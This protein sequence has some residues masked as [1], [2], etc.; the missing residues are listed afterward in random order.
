MDTGYPEDTKGMVINMKKEAVALTIAAALALGGCAAGTAGKTETPAGEPSAPEEVQKPPVGESGSPV[1]EAPAPAPEDAGNVPDTPASEPEP[2]VEEGRRDGERFEA[3]IILEGMEETV[4]YEHLRNE[5]VGVE[6]DYDYESFIRQSTPNRERFISEWDDPDDPENYLEVRYSP[7][8]AEAAAA[9]VSAEL[10][11]EYEL[12]TETR[13]LERAGDC[14][15]IDASEV[16]GGGYMPDLLQSVYIIPWTDGC[17]IVT[18]HYA[19]EGAE[20]FGRRFAYMAHTLSVID[21]EAPGALTDEQALA[22]VRKY[23][24]TVNPELENAVN[25]EDRTIYWDISSSDEQEVVVVF[26][27]YTGSLTRYYVDRAT[28]DAYVTEFVPGITEEEQR[29]EEAL[30]VWDYVE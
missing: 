28:G 29:T 5:S 21:R 3:V 24:L 4:Q 19:I 22:A 17:R 26:R 9:S 7:L 23:C 14:I 2:A 6:M 13:T 10:S 30:N 11:A 8:D 15:H 27:S 1:E 25:S 16:K 12:I 20:G 18:A